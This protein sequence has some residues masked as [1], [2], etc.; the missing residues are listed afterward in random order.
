M[1]THK[2]MSIAAVCALLHACR[3][4]PAGIAFAILHHRV[5]LFVSRLSNLLAKVD[6]T[7]L[8]VL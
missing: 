6:G 5:A 4:H 7:F 1:H 8:R 3:L 2:G